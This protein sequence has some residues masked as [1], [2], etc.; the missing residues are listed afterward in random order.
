MSTRWIVTLPPS[1]SPAPTYRDETLSVFPG[2][3]G[4]GSPRHHGGVPARRVPLQ[5]VHDGTP[6]RVA[7][8]RARVHL[9]LARDRHLRRD[10]LHGAD[11]LHVRALAAP[12]GLPR[13]GGDRAHRD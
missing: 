1:R 2:C 6:D 13:A 5:L 8:V 4:R 7:V 12:H 10:R 3:R 11:A 9:L